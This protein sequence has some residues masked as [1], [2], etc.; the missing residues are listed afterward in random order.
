MLE[1]K[2]KHLFKGVVMV[3]FWPRNVIYWKIYIGVHFFYHH[4][5]TF[6]M[7]YILSEITFQFYFFRYKIVIYMCIYNSYG[8]KF[9]T[10]TFFWNLFLPLLIHLILFLCSSFP[11]PPAIFFSMSL[12]Y[13]K[14]P[15]CIQ[16]P[17]SK[18]TLKNFM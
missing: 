15:N 5:T 12:P 2:N 7:L 6:C 14:I 17:P 10:H 11:F 4:R 16:L 1:T 3:I 9:F 18:V 13:G 8:F